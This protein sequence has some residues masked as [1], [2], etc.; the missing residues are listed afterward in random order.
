MKKLAG[1]LVCLAFFLCAVAAQAQVCT[2]EGALDAPDLIW[3]T[4]GDAEWFCQTDAGP[5][6]D[7]AQSGAIGDNQTSWLETTVSYDTPKILYFYWIVQSEQDRDYL[8]FYINGSE[9]SAISGAPSWAQVAISLLCSTKNGRFKCGLM[10][11][12]C[13]RTAL[14]KQPV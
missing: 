14:Q 9:Y 2:L 7:A 11:P 1:M 13:Q 12:F 3:T 6:G 4:G 8:R 10:R 5:F